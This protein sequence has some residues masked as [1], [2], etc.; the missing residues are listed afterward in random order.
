MFHNF[1]CTKTIVAQ[2]LNGSQSLGEIDRLQIF[3]CSKNILLQHSDTY[4]PP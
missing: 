4:E 3:I 2:S 1:T